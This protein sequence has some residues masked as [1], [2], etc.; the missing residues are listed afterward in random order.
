MNTATKLINAMQ[1]LSEQSACL[2]LI[3]QLLVAAHNVSHAQQI[4]YLLVQNN[5]DKLNNTFVFLFK[6][7][8]RSILEKKTLNAAHELAVYIGLFS[9][10]LLG[11]EL[12]ERAENIE[13]V[14]TSYEIAANFFLIQNLY[15][16]GQPLNIIWGILTANAFEVTSPRI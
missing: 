13:I 8:T 5:I 15:K 14:V 2:S 10:F 11:F 1:L 6:S 16:I 4:L 9:K 7:W 3:K 12:G